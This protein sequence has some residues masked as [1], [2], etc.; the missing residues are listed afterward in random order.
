[1]Y[2]KLTMIGHLSKDVELKYFQ[3]GTAVANFAVASNEKV[4]KADGTEIQNTLF[5]NV[6]VTGRMAEVAN[7]FLRK[8]SKV[9]VEGTLRKEE[10]VDAQGQP[11]SSYVIICEALRFLDSAPQ[12]AGY[13]QAPQPQPQAQ[14][15]QAQP[16][17]APQPQ[18]QP[19]Q[20]PQPQPTQAP[21]APQGVSNQENL[22]EINIDD[23]DIPF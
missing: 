13:Q 10:W 21:Q 16:T 6:R 8:G 18:P 9:F 2:N 12:Q 4:K 19:T 22:P 23:E 20:A 11:K 3:S 1:M 15:T 14:P 5:M 17:Q 7:Q